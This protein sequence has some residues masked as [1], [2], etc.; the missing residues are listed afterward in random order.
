MNRPILLS[1]LLLTGCS[2]T[3]TGALLMVAPDFTLQLMQLRVPQESLVFLSFIGAFVFAVGMSSF[4][5]A[6]IAFQG[7]SRTKVEVVWLLTAFSRASVAIFVIEQVLA[8]TLNPGWLT[9]AVSDGSCVLIQAVGL[10]RGWLA[11]VAR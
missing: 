8:H 6:H 10:R 3:L 2:D 5:G 4:Y 7:Q 1:Y 11:N 9:V